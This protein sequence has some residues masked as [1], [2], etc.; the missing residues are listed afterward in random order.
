MF[1]L[2]F[3]FVSLHSFSYGAGVS[4]FAGASGPSKPGS[5][6]KEPVSTSV[7]V[8]LCT[9]CYL[10]LTLTLRIA[11]S[12]FFPFATEELRIEAFTDHFLLI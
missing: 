2:E 6:L 1:I 3:V 7:L 8:P 4:K 10:N 9:V 12:P 5:D 11:P